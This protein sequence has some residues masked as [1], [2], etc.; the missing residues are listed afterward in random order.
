MPGILQTEY[1]RQAKEAKKLLRSS[2]LMLHV[3]S[4]AVAIEALEEI[5]VERG[6]LKPDELMERIKLVNQKHYAKG[7]N[8]SASED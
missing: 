7:E 2:S 6:I 5:L 8:I 1:R 4:L 3:G